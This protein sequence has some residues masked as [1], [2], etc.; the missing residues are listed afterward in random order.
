M[1]K[2]LRWLGSYLWGVK[3][4][5]YPS[6][7][8][9]TLEL[10]LINGRK[11]VNAAHVNYSFDSLHRVFQRAFR[12]VELE[13]NPP[14]RVLILGFGAG[15]VAYI[16]H[17]EYRFDCHITGVDLDPVMLQ[18]AQDE[19]Q[20][21]PSALL[22][23]LASDAVAFIASDPDTYDLLV[24]D[25]FVDDLV[26]DTVTSANFIH[27][28]KNRLAPGGRLFFNLLISNERGKQQVQHIENLF[29]EEKI[30]WLY[31]V[32]GNAVLYITNGIG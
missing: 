12:S 27:Q 22:R 17:R 24:I 9:G 2:F 29:R 13:K 5:E 15:S 16:L 19:F 20:Q 28:I 26:P 18:L 11:V 23:L 10:W 25:I 4:A 21:T 6:T 7:V 14:K 3:L 31:P 32:E 30:R 1:Q 8:S